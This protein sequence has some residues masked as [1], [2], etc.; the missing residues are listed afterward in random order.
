VAKFRETVEI[1]PASLQIPEG[2][3]T[4]L[5]DAHIARL[6]GELAEGR[7]LPLVRVRQRADGALEIIQGRHRRAA[8]QAMGKSITCE[9]FAYE[10]DAEAEYD[11]LA[12]NIIRRVLAGPERDRALARMVELRA[13]TV[14]PEPPRVGRP[15]S[16]QREAIREIAADMGVHPDT[17]A[18]A[19]ERATETTAPPLPKVAE[20]RLDWYGLEPVQA[21]EDLAEERADAVR[22]AERALRGFA[23]MIEKALGPTVGQLARSSVDRLAHMLK[24]NAPSGKVCPFCKGRSREECEACEGRGFSTVAS[25]PRQVPGELTW[26]GEDAVVARGGKFVR[27]VDGRPPKAPKTIKIVDESGEEI[28]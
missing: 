10:S 27:V 23:D 15:V 2:W 26:S 11:M 28:L 1:D 20:P 6:A 5:D 14:E 13:A 24:L 12:E 19:V 17:V 22:A 7:L 16:P 21:V 9:V 18:R 25:E 3:P 4:S 8:H